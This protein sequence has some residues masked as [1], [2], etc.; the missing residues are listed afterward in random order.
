MSTISNV[1]LSVCVPCEF[2]SQYKLAISPHSVTPKAPSPQVRESLSIYYTILYYSI[3]L[4]V[5]IANARAVIKHSTQHKIAIDRACAH[6]NMLE[7]TG[8]IMHIAIHS[9]A[10]RNVLDA[11]LLLGTQ[12][13]CAMRV[14]HHTHAT[15]TIKR[16]AAAFRR[17]SRGARKFRSLGHTIYGLR[18]CADLG[19]K[20]CAWN[21]TQTKKIIHKTTS[22]S[23]WQV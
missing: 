19:R 5:H 16:P 4:G 11:M 6:L 8:P 14:V 18:A 20:M 1:P 9:L 10:S 15:N 21:F 3:Y 2:I 13:M 12:K 17:A 23:L 7:R 22:R